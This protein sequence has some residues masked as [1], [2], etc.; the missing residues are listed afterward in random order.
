[1]ES[2]SHN[3]RDCWLLAAIIA[4]AAVLRFWHIGG[5]SLWLDEGAS[6]GIARLPWSAFL[7]LMY[8]REAN[9][10]LYY[11]LLRGWMVFGTSEAWLRALSA[12]FS[13]A[14]IPFVY[15]IGREVRS[16]A[17][18][19]V[20][21]LLFALS[22]F[23]IAY[24]E[25]I[26]SYS[27]VCL[28]VSAATW[29]LLRRRW[30]LWAWAIAL[31]V[32]AHF[33]AMLVLA[34]HVLYLVI[35]RYPLR[36][37]RTVFSKLA[38]ALIPALGFVLLR[39]TGQL[40]WIPP[41]SVAQIQQAFG[42]WAGGGDLALI[43]IFLAVLG[44]VITWRRP[45]ATNPTLVIWLWLL[46]PVVVIVVV[47]VA[48]PLLV[49]RFLILSLPALLIAAGIALTEVPKPIS[50]MLLLAIA[51]FSVRTELLAWRTPSKD[52]LRGASAY[53]LQRSSTEDGII[54]HIP[55]ARHAFEYYAR[56]QRASNVPGLMS[57]SHGPRATERDFQA[58][59][60]AELVAKLWKKPPVLWLMLTRNESNGQPDEYT[61]FVMSKVKEVYA[62][63]E[64]RQFRGVLVRRCTR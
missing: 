14:T 47:S 2:S 49:S 27:L 23:S 50:V 51:F 62:Q 24:A 3:R 26:R 39:N 17:T 58:D 10:V 1:M 60:D 44:A 61:N 28:L 16:R 11:V 22:P 35:T 48:R 5:E 34:S 21:A 29:F 59:G 31:A 13:V 45:I 20:A 15:V 19:F 46:V 43:V 25:E 55:M 56:R 40:T 53:V 6:V 8:E 30:T 41:L 52:D 33:F 64:D 42:E 38:L 57:P 37:L 54:F 63:C 32:Y 4:I 18:G 7:K 12:V 9:M 36:D